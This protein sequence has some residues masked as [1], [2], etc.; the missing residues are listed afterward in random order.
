MKFHLALL[1]LIV[2]VDGQRVTQT[3]S[4]TQD[5]QPTPTAEAPPPPS[6]PTSSNVPKVAPTFSPNAA[7]ALTTNHIVLWGGLLWFLQ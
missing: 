6:S 7:S 2:L 1:V 5:T 3:A 4:S